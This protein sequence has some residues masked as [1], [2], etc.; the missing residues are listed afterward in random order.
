M[1]PGQEAKV[2]MLHNTVKKLKK[3][4]KKKGK[5]FSIGMNTV[6]A[7]VGKGDFRARRA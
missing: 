3:K 2:N 5:L 6:K 4:K 1:I 7:R